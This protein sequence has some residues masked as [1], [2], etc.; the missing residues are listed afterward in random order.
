MNLYLMRHGIA[1][2]A[3]EPGINSDNERPLSP[4]GMKRLR[5][6]ARGL[7]RLHIGFSSILTSPVLRARQTAEI[8]AQSLGLEAR[9]EEISG[10]APESSVEHLMLGLTR[11][12]DQEDVLLVGHEPLLSDTASFLLLSKNKPNLNIRFRKGGLCCIEIDD[13]PPTRPGLLR[14]YLTA[15]HLRLLAKAGHS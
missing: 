14:W 3:D 12:H 1:V 7:A 4:K 13:L 9:L 6:A 15:K 11:F 2:A 8:V 5:R 10:L